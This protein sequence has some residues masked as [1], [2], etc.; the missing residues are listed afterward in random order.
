[1]SDWGVSSA[2]R[3]RR[4]RRIAATPGSNA[5]EE[6]GPDLRFPTGVL[7]RLAQP[8]LGVAA[9]MVQ[10]LVVLAPQPAVGRD[11]HQQAA[12]WAGRATQLAQ[13]APIVVQVLDHVGGER[14]VETAALEGQILQR[15]LLYA[16][17]PAT[18]AEVDGLRRRVH[19]L[20]LPE[21]AELHEVAPGAATGIE[22]PRR[23]VDARAGQQR[24]DHGAPATKPP[25]PVFELVQLA[26]PPVVHRVS[27]RGPRRASGRR[28]ARAG[29][30]PASRRPGRRPS[31][32]PTAGGP[33]RAPA[34]RRPPRARA[35]RGW[36]LPD[37]PT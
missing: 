16:R 30:K 11:S 7:Q 35:P 21:A 1:M 20:G 26:V 31:R 27:A 23:R 33:P 25:V 17:E 4:S 22:Q 19:A 12:A 13:R 32:S 14:E 37:G 9:P 29:S 24:P 6:V 10:R 34:G 5:R 2:G 36:S 8:A 28:S 15:G 18:T 3:S